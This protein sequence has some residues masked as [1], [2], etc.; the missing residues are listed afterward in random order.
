MSLV[1]P[2]PISADEEC[3]YGNDLSIYDGVRPGMMGLHALDR[4]AKQSITELMSLNRR[5]ILFQSL[6]SD[7]RILIRFIPKL[8]IGQI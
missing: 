3:L 2:K 8:L 4:D 5:Y 6:N 1:G 7:I